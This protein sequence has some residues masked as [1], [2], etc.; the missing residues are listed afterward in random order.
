M[1]HSVLYGV[2]SDAKKKINSYYLLVLENASNILY[3]YISYK[4]I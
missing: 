3:R 1:I 4:N 2:N